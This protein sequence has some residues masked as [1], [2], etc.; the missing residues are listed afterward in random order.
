LRHASALVVALCFGMAVAVQ[1][2]DGVVVA[3][4][5]AAVELAL[6]V[7]GHSASP[8]VGSIHGLIGAPF[9]IDRRAS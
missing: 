1:A 5:T 6:L 4:L 8:I 7:G 3:A 2:V 9:L